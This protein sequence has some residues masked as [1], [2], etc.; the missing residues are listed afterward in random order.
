MSPTLITDLLAV[1]HS[2]RRRHRVVGRSPHRGA[3]GALFAE[4]PQ[5]AHGFRRRGETRLS[6]RTPAPK[7][8]PGLLGFP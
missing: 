8:S 6:R 4:R 2:K 3:L 1:D 7:E 5:A